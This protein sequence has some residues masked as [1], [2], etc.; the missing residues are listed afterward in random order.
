MTAAFVRRRR[1]RWLI[2][3]AVLLVLAAAALW[4]RSLLQPERLSAFLLQR[5][6]QAT[7]LQ[8]TLD[9]PARVGFWPDLHLELDGLSARIPGESSPL[10][11]AQRVETAL[12]WSAL[13]SETL[14]LQG[15]RLFQPEL[16]IDAMQRWL[17]SRQTDGPPAPFQLPELDAPLSVEEGTIRAGSPPAILNRTGR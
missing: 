9:Q 12:P 11:T 7:G 14:Q 13:R 5:A 3:F 15:L 16:D 4:L 1:R 8:I 17:A 2:A 6:S 10:L